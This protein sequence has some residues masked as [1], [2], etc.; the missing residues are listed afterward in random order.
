MGN[1]VV[2]YQGLF[3]L[4]LK[5]D[6]ETGKV[7][8]YLNGILKWMQEKTMSEIMKAQ[9]DLYIV[10]GENKEIV[11]TEVIADLLNGEKLAF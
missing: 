4:N 3:G 9:K 1:A 6:L 2:E 8:V 7:E 11:V 5:M 10:E